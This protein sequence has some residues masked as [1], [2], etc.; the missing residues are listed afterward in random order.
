M[1]WLQLLFVRSLCDLLC[2]R[3]KV[4]ICRTSEL[5]TDSSIIKQCCAIIDFPTSG[6][7]IRAS[8]VSPGAAARHLFSS[9]RD[10]LVHRC[11]VHIGDQFVI[12]LSRA[13]TSCARCRLV[14]AI[15]EPRPHFPSKPTGRAARVQRLSLSPFL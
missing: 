8:H 13:H 14:W 11:C 5:P 10:Q 6:P 4:D 2:A 1:I 15:L 9:R 12:S 7:D 3:F